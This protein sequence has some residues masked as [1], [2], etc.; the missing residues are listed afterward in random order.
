MHFRA[1]TGE[2]VELP[3]DP[4]VSVESVLPEGATTCVV[5]IRCGVRHV[6]QNTT[7]SI[8]AGGESTDGTL[9]ATLSALA[10]GA[11]QPAVFVDPTIAEEE[12]GSDR[13]GDAQLRLES[14]LENYFRREVLDYSADYTCEKC[15]RVVELVRELQMVHPPLILILHL[16]RFAFDANGA[17]KIYENVKYPLHVSVANGVNESDWMFR[18]SSEC[19]R[20]AWCGDSDGGF[21]VDMTC[22]A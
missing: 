10:M 12:R 4:G 5:S 7:L 6:I 17:V 14:C 13:H 16:M 19:R 3:S 8:G 1:E 2:T 18:S 22:S 11:S 20:E 9:L 15:K 21:S